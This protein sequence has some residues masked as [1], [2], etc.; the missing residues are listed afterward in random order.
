MVSFEKTGQRTEEFSTLHSVVAS[1]HTREGG[2][3]ASHRIEAKYVLDNELDSEYQNKQHQDSILTR[4]KEKK[5]VF[6]YGEFKIKNKL[7]G[8]ILF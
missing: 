3:S 8:F 6:K 7:V 2:V 1:E 4:Y 5:D